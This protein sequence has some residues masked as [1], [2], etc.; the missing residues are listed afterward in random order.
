MRVLVITV[1]ALALAAAAGASDEPV[2]IYVQFHE[3]DNTHLSGS[4]AGGCSVLP[5]DA[6]NGLFYRNADGSGI[7]MGS[8]I[9]EQQQ[10][11]FEL[12]FSAQIEPTDQSQDLLV[13]TYLMSIDGKGTIVE[14]QKKTFREPVRFGNQIEIPIGGLFAEDPISLSIKVGT[15]SDPPWGGRSGDL[16]QVQLIST[17]IGP[18]ESSSRRTTHRRQ[19]GPRLDFSSEFRDVDTDQADRK[20]LRYN[21]QAY[22]EGWQEGAP[23]SEYTLHYKRSYMVDSSHAQGNQSYQINAKFQSVYTRAV[24]LSY[25]KVIKLVFPP[26]EPSVHGFDIEDTLIIYHGDGGSD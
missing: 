20:S 21:V 24:Q 17:N 9:N 19:L 12:L 5:G 13:S 25:E 4:V 3:G 16:Y 22:L 15:R 23:P 26:D 10:A 1:V 8:I 14:G 6:C 11:D 7:Y 18:A 2:Y